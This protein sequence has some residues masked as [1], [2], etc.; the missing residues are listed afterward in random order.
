MELLKR[1]I[2]T[3]GKAINSHVLKVDS[4]LNHQ[5]NPALMRAIG[6][7]F[8]DI[9]ENRGI[10]R[11]VTVE[12]SGIAPALMTAEI[13][14]LPLVI[15][16]KQPSR[17]QDEELLQCEVTSFTKGNTYQLTVTRSYLPAGEKVLIIDDFLAYGEA[18]FGAINLIKQA[19]ATVG[20]I[21]VVIE[22]S[23]QP[24]HDRLVQAGYDLH[25]LARVKH[26]EPGK[27]EFI[28]D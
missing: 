11:V 15:M 1:Q 24:G 16:K 23:F 7:E 9:F 8:A 27:I 4:F 2:L 21:G 26:M 3:Y 5:V 22:K 17:A 20:G 14:K 10:N 19:G 12:S 25:A 6:E 18:A 13:L 28:D